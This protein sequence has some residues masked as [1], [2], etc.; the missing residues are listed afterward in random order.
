MIAS[1]AGVTTEI[2]NRPDQE[3]QHALLITFEQGRVDFRGVTQLLMLA[4]GAYQFKGGFKGE[5]IGRRGLKWRI[6]CAGGAGPLGESAMLIGATPAW[7][8]VEFSFTVPDDDCRAQQLRLDLDARMSSEQL[9]TGAMWFDE[10]KIGRLARLTSRISGLARDWDA[11]QA[12]CG[13]RVACLT[14]RL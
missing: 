11:V 14:R 4:P 9:V 1:G 13:S 8:D 5:I 7:R 3:G 6:A 12:T 2:L 10:L